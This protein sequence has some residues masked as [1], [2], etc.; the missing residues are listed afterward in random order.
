MQEIT[1]MTGA[2]AGALRD[3]LVGKVFLELQSDD[4]AAARVEGGEAEMDQADAFEADD[5]G[6]GQGIGIGRGGLGRVRVIG[7]GGGKGFERDGSGGLAE[8]IDGEVV[9]GAIE[10]ASGFEDGSE[11]GVKAHEGF[12]GDVLGGFAMAGETLGV[13]EQG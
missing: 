4:F 1:D 12:L 8:L 9:D 10:P 13:G 7:R 6:I 3:F 2:Q 5:V 11:L